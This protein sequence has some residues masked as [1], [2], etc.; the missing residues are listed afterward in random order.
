MFQQLEQFVK[1]TFKTT[2]EI[3]LEALRL[4]PN[5]RGYISGSVT[6]LLLKRHIESL[7]YTVERIREK[8]EGEK[9]HHGDFYFAKNGSNACFVLES[10]GIKSNS[11]KWH[12]LYNRK[13]LVRFLCENHNIIPWIIQS[14]EIEPQVNHWLNKNL[15]KFFNEYSAPLY[16]YV[17]VQS[18]LKNAP[19]KETEK[20]RAVALLQNLTREQIGE[21]IAE[22]LHYVRSKIGVL[23]TH[24]VSGASKKN[25]RKIAT[26]RKEEFHIISIDISLRYPEHKFLFANPQ[27]LDS[28]GDEAE[29]LKQNYIIGFVF[30]E[31]D[32]NVTLCLS[33]EWF[34]DFAEVVNSLDKSTAVNPDDKQVDLRN[35]I[36]TEE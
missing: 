27:L 15:P 7:G 36:Y 18:Y 24:F 3:F 29:H 19:K 30:T 13:P 26:P 22:R 2:V 9:K 21:M 17:E 6:E 1:T 8:W 33:D 11:E 34:A 25:G 14:Q 23:E 32:G 5:A 31:E 35:I 20:S 10:K 12:K 16:G 4:S 28:S